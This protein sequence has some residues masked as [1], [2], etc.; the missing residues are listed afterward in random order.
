VLKKVLLAI[1]FLLLVWIGYEWLTFP[2]VAKLADAP[3]DTTAFMEARKERLRAEGKSDELR[4]TWVPYSRI[5]PYLRRAVL[6]A[7]DNAFYDHEGIDVEALREAMKT[8]LER[9]RMVYGGSTITQQLAK[10]LYLSPSRNPVRKIR[11]YLI[12]RSLE[13]HLSKKRILEIYLNVVE[14]GE[15]VYGAEAASRHY[16]GK[17][18]AALTPP[19]AALLAGALPNPRNMNPGDPNRRLRARQKMILSRMKRW[20]YVVEREALAETKPPEATKETVPADPDASEIPATETTDTTASSEEEA[21]PVEPAT[22]TT[23]TETD[24]PTDTSATETS[25]T[26]TFGR[27]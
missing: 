24:A 6:V 11:E 17:S 7:E 21:P 1:L 23:V 13:K 26:D 18:A 19:Q 14:L 8:N 9:R 4:W 27:Q 25:A 22:D 3:P 10:N 2:D 20:G 5:S 15:R 16:F 12:A